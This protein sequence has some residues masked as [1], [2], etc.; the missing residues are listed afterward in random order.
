LAISRSTYVPAAAK[1]A[2]VFAALALPNVTAAGPLNADQDNVSVLGGFGS[3]SSLA[4]PASVA[5][6]GSVMV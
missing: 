1:L 3:P 2:V 4:V 6:A 5:T